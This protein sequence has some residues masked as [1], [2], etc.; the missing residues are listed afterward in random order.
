MEKVTKVTIEDISKALNLSK[1][2]IYR[3]LHN[4]GRV[5]E[6]TK[7]RVKEYAKQIGYQPNISAQG[8]AR[9]KKYKLACLYPIARKEIADWWIPV[10]E[11]TEKAAQE[12]SD[13]GS[14]VTFFYYISDNLIDPS[15]HTDPSI[16][17]NKIENDE[18]D[19]L[20]LVPSIQHDVMSILNAANQK[21]IPVVCINADSPLSSQR[22]FYYG[23]DE[24][25]AG[26]LAGELLGK[27]MNAQGHM[28]LVGADGTDFYRIAF[29]KKGVFNQLCQY[30]PKIKV[31]QYTFPRNDFRQYLRNMLRDSPDTFSALYVPEA[32]FLFD[33]AQ[34][35]KELNLTNIVVVGHECIGDC[36]QLLEEGWIHACICQETFSQGYYPVKLLY[37]ALLNGETLKH[38]YHSNVNVVFRCNSIQLCENEEGCGFR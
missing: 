38:T 37:R 10:R 13:F 28:A 26:Q 27:F 23:P 7:Q 30:F 1:G 9:Q 35:I 25:R 22:L 15:S 36:K 12:L 18:V 2:T 34:I 32:A 21:N 17:L 5:S 14:E 8:I 3:S 6:K 29:R 20:L 31:T 33:S 19:A 16:L 24:E 4:T 11:G